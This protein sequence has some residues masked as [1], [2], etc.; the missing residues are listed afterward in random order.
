TTSPCV[1]FAPALLYAGNGGVM[2]PS[3]ESPPGGADADFRRLCFTFAAIGLCARVACTGG[4]LTRARYVAFREAFPP[5][6]EECGKIRSLSASACAD[7]PPF[8]HYVRQIPRAFPH[9][10]TLY[11]SLLE[12]LF[13]IA[14]ADGAPADEAE[15]LLAQVAGAL[16]VERRE[17]Q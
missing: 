2:L 6:A 16:G 3:L 10:E 1:P 5:E 17:Y 14:A 8:T 9:A 12:R 4:G 13:S 11:A 7:P 15:S